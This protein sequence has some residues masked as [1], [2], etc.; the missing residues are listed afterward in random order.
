MRYPEPQFYDFTT[1]VIQDGKLVFKSQVRGST[2]GAA[3]R[4][5]LKSI[6]NILEYTK[7]LE[8][9]N[10]VYAT[11][12]FPD[13][14]GTGLVW[15]SGS[16]ILSINGLTDYLLWH[17]E[18]YYNHEIRFMLG[19]WRIKV[20]HVSFNDYD[21]S[22]ADRIEARYEIADKI[23]SLLDEFKTE[24]AE[25]RRKDIRV[26]KKM[27]RE[28]RNELRWEHF[29]NFFKSRRKTNSEIFTT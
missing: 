13:H 25:A 15:S 12:E 22:L 6:P 20:D 14:F 1:R 16:S 23:D 8:D 19:G 7:R 2:P 4:S 17:A 28:D 11:V 3:F 18:A 24:W 5:Y 26:K 10:R 27:D 9:F 21:D 29:R